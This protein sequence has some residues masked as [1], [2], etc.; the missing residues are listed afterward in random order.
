M[1][2]CFLPTAPALIMVKSCWLCHFCLILC[3]AEPEVPYYVAVVPMNSVGPGVQGETIAFT[4]EGGMIR[5]FVKFLCMCVC[6]CVCVYPCVSVST[7][8]YVCT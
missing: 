8:V 7:C 1:C 2:T 3:F 4:L 6:V 5:C